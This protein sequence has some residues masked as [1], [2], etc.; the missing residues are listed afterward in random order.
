M[1]ADEASRSMARR[2]CLLS[3]PPVPLFR[4]PCPSARPPARSRSSHPAARFR[5]T[6]PSG[7]CRRLCTTHLVVTAR[8]GNLLSDTTL[9]CSKPSPR[10]HIRCWCRTDL[11]RHYIRIDRPRIAD[12]GPLDQHSVDGDLFGGTVNAQGALGFVGDVAPAEVAGEIAAARPLLGARCRKGVRRREGL[13][14]YLKGDLAGA[15]KRRLL[16]AGCPIRR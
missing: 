3:T 13:K 10:I 11:A 16:Q 4:R 9:G 14:P 15:T 5:A 1:P 8:I 12:G 2:R 6:C 7:C